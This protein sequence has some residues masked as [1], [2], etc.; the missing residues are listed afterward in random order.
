MKGSEKQ[1]PSVTTSDLIPPPTGTL[2]FY[3]AHLNFEL[4]RPRMLC[5]TLKA[6]CDL[7]AVGVY[8]ITFCLECRS[9]LNY[10]T[11]ALNWA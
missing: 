2:S 10:T 9:F 8:T 1:E 7:S 3:L 6:V 11:H 5:I 4:N